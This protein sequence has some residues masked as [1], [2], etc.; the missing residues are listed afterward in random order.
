MINATQM[1]NFLYMLPNE[2]KLLEG[3]LMLRAGAKKS[4]G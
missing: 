1:G 2:S 4:E 3:Y